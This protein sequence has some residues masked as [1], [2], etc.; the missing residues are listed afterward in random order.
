MQWRDRI[1]VV[2]KSY[3][4]RNCSPSSPQQLKRTGEGSRNAFLSSRRSMTLRKG[5]LD[6]RTL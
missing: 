1:A 6:R 5:C 4:F 2:V 3:V